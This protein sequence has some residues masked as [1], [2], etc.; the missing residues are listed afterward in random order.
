M[1]RVQLLVVLW[2]GARGV[3]RARGSH[4]T[5]PT[6][7]RVDMPARAIP[8]TRA[9][10]A[11]VC[12]RITDCRIAGH[13]ELAPQMPLSSFEMGRI[14]ASTQTSRRRLLCGR[15][16]LCHSEGGPVD[17]RRIQKVDCGR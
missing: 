12:R 8:V 17:L 5:R 11:L 3:R 14:M 16:E 1:Q 13:W 2:G 4:E 7:G 9:A 15:R 6:S 10:Y